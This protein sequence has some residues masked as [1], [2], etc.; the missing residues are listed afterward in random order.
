LDPLIAVNP[1]CV[2]GED[3][4]EKRIQLS[5]LFA[6]NRNRIA[7]PYINDVTKKL[8]GYIEGGPESA[9]ME[10]D[11]K[12]LCAKFTT[13][14]VAAVAFGLDGESFTNPDASF[15]KM[16]DDIFKPSFWTGL[17]QQLVLFMPFLNKFLRV[18]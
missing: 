5:P 16:G 1:F 12:D 11:V 13:D 15:R 7:I 17:S 8:L 6:Q 4:K 3:W 9:K 2:P 18:P 14:N 10:F